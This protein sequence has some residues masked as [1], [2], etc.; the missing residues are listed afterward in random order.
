MT[1]LKVFSGACLMVG[2]FGKVLDNATQ[3]RPE[4][5]V[6]LFLLVV[7]LNFDESYEA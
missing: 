5:V 2:I 6:F 3:N 1:I 4:L 7:N